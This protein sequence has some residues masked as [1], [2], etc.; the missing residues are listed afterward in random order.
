[1]KILLNSV[2]RKY[3]QFPVA[4]LFCEH[5]TFFKNMYL[6]N[7]IK[8]EIKLSFKFYVRKNYCTSDK[9]AKWAKWFS[10]KQQRTN[11]IY[12]Y[13]ILKKKIGNLSITKKKVFS[14]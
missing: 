5:I 7:Y 14:Y 12:I 8:T 6:Q 2:L 9:I 13:I 11:N 10:N 4:I 3:D 1:M